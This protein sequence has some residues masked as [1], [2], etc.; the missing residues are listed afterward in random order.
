MHDTLKAD[1]RTAGPS[2][3]NDARADLLK[4]I[5]RKEAERKARL[6]DAPTPD[7]GRRTSVELRYGA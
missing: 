7:F 2:T 4:M 5:L 3:R 6:P 1:S